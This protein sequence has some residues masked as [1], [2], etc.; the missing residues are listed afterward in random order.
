M[1]FYKTKFYQNY[2]KNIEI[3][4][5]YIEAA[6]IS[7]YKLAIL[8]NPNF[9]EAH[10]KL[11]RLFQKQ[12]KWQEAA[13]AFDQAI[14][15]DCLN[16]AD[17]YH[18]LGQTL[19][20]AKQVEESII[21]SRQAIELEPDR[22]SYYLQLGR[23]LSVKSKVSEAIKNFQIASQKQVSQ[24]HPHVVL[25]S[26]EKLQFSAPNFLIIGQVKC[27]TSSLYGYLTQHPQILPAI[28]KEIQF[29]HIES[30]F[31]HG[32]DWYLSQFPAISSEPNLITGEATPLYIN[33]Q[34]AAE[35]VFQTFPNIK[36]IVLLRNPIDQVISNYYMR[37]RGHVENISLEKAIALALKGTP[38]ASNSDL[39]EIYDRRYL[40]KGRYIEVISQ[41]MNL[42]PKNQFLIVKSEDFF[43]ETATTLNQVC[44][45]LEVESYQI[46]EYPKINQGSYP[47]ISHSMRQTL[48]DYFRPFNQQLEEYLDRK[49]NWNS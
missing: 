28:R 21:A 4:L 42:F 5:P 12:K 33:S 37:V 3:I 44:Q 6:I 45:F 25:K 31:N 8:L 30:T 13:I 29:W 23:A 32:L 15:N 47:P 39:S 46:Q 11:G 49:F 24:T 40:R 22:D 9:S 19:L 2:S 27:G 10:Y 14:K 1:A 26:L 36:L 17:A 48:N 16:L 43:T 34:P 20:N 38:Q 7:C 18:R 35:R 41:W